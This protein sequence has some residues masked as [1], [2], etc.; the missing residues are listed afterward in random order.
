M[1]IKFD[2]FK[3]GA[4]KIIT[5]SYDD[6]RIHD[7]RLVEI[8]NKYNMKST[9]HLNSGLIKTERHINM[10]EIP[11]LY[12]NHEVASHGEFHASM[13]LIPT[14]NIAHEIVEDRRILESYCGY[15][16]RGCSYP[17]GYSH[18]KYA[19]VLSCCGIEYSRTVNNTGK[20]GLPYDFLLWDP[21]CHHRDA[22]SKGTQFINQKPNATLL[23]VW[24]HS[25]EFHENNN[26]ELIEEFCKIVSGHENIWY[27]TNIEIVDYIKAQHNLKISYD[28]KII[29]N[30]SSC[31]V[32]FSADGQ[33]MSVKGGSILKL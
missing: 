4:T 31:K 27:A 23:Y 32:W 1:I 3:N 8:L 6:G 10:D 28:N 20:F 33:T 19:D 16:V 30:P 22:I 13:N 11:T 21:T 29:M 5:L 2:R 14:Q 12:A 17:N 9:F 24:G 15:P 25:Y 18:Q 26:W 7:R